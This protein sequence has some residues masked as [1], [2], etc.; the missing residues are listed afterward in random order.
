M[1]LRENL[2]GCEC[3]LLYNHYIICFSIWMRMDG[4]DQLSKKVGPD[5]RGSRWHPFF[6]DVDHH[7]MLLKFGR[8]DGED[9]RVIKSSKTA[10][11]TMGKFQQEQKI[12]RG[13]ASI[14]A[15]EGDADY[16]SGERTSWMGPLR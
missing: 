15:R 8:S 3:F 9:H 4:S 10:M 12:R 5:V 2:N 1:G 14:S 11:N 7:H 6:N 13:W 16:T